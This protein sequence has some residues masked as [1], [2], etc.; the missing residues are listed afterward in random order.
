MVF[1]LQRRRTKTLINLQI[2]CFPLCF[3]F[4]T[5][6]CSEPNQ[7]S[8]STSLGVLSSSTIGLIWKNFTNSDVASDQCFESA[9]DWFLQR[10]GTRCENYM[11]NKQN[12]KNNAYHNQRIKV[13]IWRS[14]LL[15]GSFR[16]QQHWGARDA[17]KKKVCC[18]WRGLFPIFH[19]CL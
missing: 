17:R 12:Q 4:Q 16:S 1:N 7:H 15:Q 11:H 5:T 6:S 10:V 8:Q 9:L 2:S 18:L 19:F 14:C 3:T 13:I